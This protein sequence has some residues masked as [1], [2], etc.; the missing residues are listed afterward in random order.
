MEI[1]SSFLWII[2][3]VLVVHNVPL[4][5]AQAITMQPIK[6]IMNGWGSSIPCVALQS[7]NA[8]ISLS[9]FFPFWLL[10]LTN[11]LLASVDVKVHQQ[12][13]SNG[14]VYKNSESPLDIELLMMWPIICFE[15]ISTW[16]VYE[17][18]NSGQNDLCTNSDRGFS[19]VR[20]MSN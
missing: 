12:P 7:S 4:L 11:P 8:L 20:R 19:N 3:K 17:K 6:R 9:I 10:L 13:H 14:L 16:L 15:K 5:S 18:S 1:C 2:V